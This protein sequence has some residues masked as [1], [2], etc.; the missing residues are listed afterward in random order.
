MSQNQSHREWHWVVAG[1]ALGLV[2]TFAFATGHPVGTA[3]TY[4]RVAGHILEFISPEYVANT[5]HYYREAAPV[6]EWQTFFVLGLIVAGLIARFFVVGKKAED[7]P[8]MF[9]QHISRSPGRRYW[10]AFLGG[11][12]L[13]FGSRLA[14]G[15]TS[16]LFMSGGSQLALASLV[17]A[18]GMFV[19]GVI[20]AKLLYRGRDV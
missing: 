10:H 12:F 1:I 20:T 7:V 11:V 18:A 13:L 5:V 6:A 2:I 17:F 3:T 19:S 4:E 16:G 14:G 8:E 15:C 9:A